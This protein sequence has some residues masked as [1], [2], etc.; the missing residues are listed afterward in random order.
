MTSSR[1]VL[2]RKHGKERPEN[3]F[4]WGEWSKFYLINQ[5]IFVGKLRFY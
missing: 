4:E 1:N 5:E 2:R 3:D